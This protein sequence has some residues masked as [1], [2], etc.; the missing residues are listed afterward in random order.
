MTDS[1][2][3]KISNSDIYNNAAY[4]LRYVG[5]HNS[6][7]ENSKIYNTAGGAGGTAIFDY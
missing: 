1:H 3:N 7:V 4:G 6:I 5:N 2:Y